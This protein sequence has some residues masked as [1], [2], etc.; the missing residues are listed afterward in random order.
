MRYPETAYFEWLD[1]VW[2]APFVGE[3]GSIRLA[4]K[5]ALANHIGLEG[6]TQ[7]A[8]SSQLRPE[9]SP[10]AL[11]LVGRDRGISRGPTETDT[12]YRAR[13]AA[14]WTAW[15]YA[16]TAYTI[17]SQLAL[18]GVTAEVKGNNDWNWDGNTLAWA[19]FWVVIT[20]HPWS[21]SSWTWGDGTQWGDGSL[22]GSGASAAETDNVR[23]IIRQW[24]PAHA[25]CNAIIIVND[26][27]TWAAEQPDGTWGDISNR[28][29]AASYVDL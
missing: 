14:A 2:P 20:A 22:W 13:V 16:G 12:Q 17:I 28:T 18:L 27:V 11:T 5:L 10:D 21:T 25:Y 9:M 29:L 3:V 6:D 23:R 4:V 8:K 26:P 19:R 24:K 7:A 1:E 15:E